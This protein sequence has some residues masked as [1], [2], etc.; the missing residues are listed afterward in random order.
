MVPLW[1]E[2]Q[3]LRIRDTRSEGGAETSSLVALRNERG[4]G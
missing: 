2:A 1:E 4:S 3:D